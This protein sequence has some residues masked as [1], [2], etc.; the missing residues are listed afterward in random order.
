[1]SVSADGLIHDV[2]RWASGQP[3][4]RALVLV[5]SQARGAA[6]PDSDVDLVIVSEQPARLLND[7]AWIHT[8]GTVVQQATEEWGRLKSLRIRYDEG[9]EVESGVTDVAWADPGDDSTLA[10]LLDG[11]RVLLDRD[12]LFDFL[13]PK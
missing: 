13:A 6:R 2:V 4:V 9:P 11:A 8:F 5:G 12:G 10:V 3:E 1:M 7:R